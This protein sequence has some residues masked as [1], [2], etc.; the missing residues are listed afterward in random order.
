MTKRPVAIE[1]DVQ[2]EAGI[3]ASFKWRNQWYSVQQVLMHWIESGPWWIALRGDFASEFA[4][5]D[6]AD[7][8]WRIWRVEANSAH[9][10]LV[11]D[12]AFRESLTSSSA[13]PWRLIRI[14]D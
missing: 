10:K 6:S 7:I 8:T 4:D 5:A 2:A 1:I 13:F 11:A 3:P 14:F 12:I 9:G